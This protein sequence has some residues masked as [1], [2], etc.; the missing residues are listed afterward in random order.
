MNI[1]AAFRAWNG[2]LLCVEIP[3]DKRV[4]LQATAPQLQQIKEIEI[5]L[6]EGSR[7]QLLNVK[8]TDDNTLECEF[9]VF[10]P[11]YLIDIST[12]AE[13]FRPFGHHPLNYVLSRFRTSENTRHIL[14]GNAA[15]YFIDELVNQKEEETVEYGAVLKR[16]FTISP[17]EFTAC[18]DLKDKEMEQTFF[19]ACKTQFDHIRRVIEQQFPAEGIDRADII[20]EPSFIS[21]LL[22]IQGRLD[23]MLQDFSA[24][25]EL[26]SGKGEEDF[27]SGKF[28][29]SS[30][31]HYT[32]MILYLAVMEFNLKLRHQDVRSYLLYSK[33]P[34]LS[35]EIHS[36]TRLGE[37]LHL[38]NRMVALDYLVQYHNSVD[39]TDRVLS[40]IHAQRLNEKAL[41]GRFF[42]NYLA[43]QINAFPAMLQ[44]LDETERSYF[45]R[46]YAFIVK[47]MWQ[48]K[49]GEREYEGLSCS[50][51]LWNASE[52]EKMAAGEFL[53]GLK[54]EDNQADSERHAITLSI[55]EYGDHYMPN[56]RQG[57]AVVLYEWQPGRGLSER[58]VFK[59]SVEELAGSVI[60]VRL[61]YRQRN[62]SVLPSEAT[63][64]IEHDYMDTVFA[65]MY[66]GLTAFA[67]ANPER[68]ALLL[69][70]RMPEYN[71]Q[72]LEAD[73]DSPCKEPLDGILNKILSSE[74]CFL[75]VGPP[76]TGK[77]SQ[78]LKRTVEVL[79]REEKNMLL[80]A[81]TNRAVDEI[82]S[83]LVA[84]DED[85][86]FIRVG[87]ELNCAP[88]YRNYLL[89]K[90]LKSCER[91]TEV[92]EMIEKTPII[93]ATVASAWSKP[94]LF[95]LKRFDMAIIDEATQLLEPHLLGILSIKDEQG[96]NAVER[97]VLIGDHKQLPAVIL[98][99]SA[100]SEVKD[101]I[102]QQAGLRNLNESLF[103]RLYRAYRSSGWKH[104]FD[105]LHQQGRM[106]PAIEE[107]PSLFF[108]GGKL[109]TLG[110]PHQ[111]EGAPLHSPLKHRLVY[112][113]SEQP[114]N[115]GNHKANRHEAQIIAGYLTDLSDYYQQEG[116]SPDCQSIGIITPY[117]NQIALIRKTLREA[118]IGNL[119][120]IVID[121]VERF[122][123]GQKD[124]IIY[125]FCLNADWQLA[126]L[127]NCTE[128]EG[129]PIDRK[130]NVVMT[131]A[132][133]Q[134]VITGNKDFLMRN[135]LYA[136]LLRFIEKKGV[137]L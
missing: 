126:S 92:Q 57:D 16:L 136:S 110:L 130:L 64:A 70:R 65:G 132:R 87:G 134:L 3:P 11:D 77:T 68:R 72:R 63:Y 115:V 28:R 78:A 34:V 45:M 9:I 81:Y 15:N 35:K 109:R 44:G 62:I 90:K 67:Q 38:R 104:A 83:A 37:A 8:E 117:R 113:P 106:H 93:V 60:K 135:E 125:S 114:A 79:H 111:Q 124:I 56:F 22:G 103:E 119:P 94:D 95:R 14:L 96:R 2:D 123:G 118:A 82:C 71:K 17:F 48:A 51:N 20:V 107:F 40:C 13:C 42:E 108:Y 122:Q 12:L 84:I 50:A 49:V 55:P 10:E 52:E 99:T 18:Q 101:E 137:V 53:Y 89:D 29:Y 6:H 33:Y 32:Q 88:P 59:G 26:K 1:R 100:E 21:N 112:F 80:L 74:E 131:R 43:P 116:L 69:G 66:K 127:P 120:E 47:E 27:R 46:L 129:K 54:I 25:V 24:F 4:F 73:T 75:L 121:T 76:G 102:L 31:N 98:Q 97:F 105:M 58:Q 133:K 91:R 19:T 30:P 41:S 39:Y 7:L 61:R 86:P 5:A 128:E 36:R 23:L 85:I